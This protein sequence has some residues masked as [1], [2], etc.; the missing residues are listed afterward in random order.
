MFSGGLF[1]ASLFAASILP[2]ST[3][4]AV[5]EAF[6][7]IGL[8]LD[9]SSNGG[10]SPADRDIALQASAVRILVIAA[11]ED[12]SILRQVKRVLRWS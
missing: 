11:R 4:Y 10:S 12:L 8:R 2:I 3:A 1:N 7:Y 6:G 9:P 5:C